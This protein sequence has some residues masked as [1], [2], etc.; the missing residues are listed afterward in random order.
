LGHLLT[1]DGCRR[2]S[3]FAGFKE[4]E[5]RHPNPIPSHAKVGKGRKDLLMSA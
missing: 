2:A 5:K 4:A 3:H 1:I